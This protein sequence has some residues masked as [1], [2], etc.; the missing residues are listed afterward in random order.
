MPSEHEKQWIAAWREAGPELERIRNEELKAL[1]ESAGQ[2]LLQSGSRQVYATD[3]SGLVVFQAWMSRW[4][5]MQLIVH[6][7]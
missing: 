4:Y 6:D 5:I 3:L 1:D 2:Q 7:A